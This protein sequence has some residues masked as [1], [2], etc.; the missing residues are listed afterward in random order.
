MNKNKEI[1]LNNKQSLG[2]FMKNH[3]ALYLML[4]P[5]LIIM[6]VFKFLPYYGIQ[7]AFKDYNIFAGNSPLAAIGASTWVGMKHFNKLF[8]SPEFLKVLKNTLVINGSRILFLFPIPIVFAIALGEIRNYRYM[9]FTQT[10][11]FIPY[12]FSWVIIYGIFHSMLGTYGMLNSIVNGLFGMERLAFFRD[13]DL[14]RSMIIFTDGWKSVGYNTVI[15]LAAILSIDPSLYDSARIDG[16][17]RFRQI[18][19]ITIPGILPTIVLMLI[20]KVGHILD[21]GFEQILIFYNPA[22][23]E[24]ADTIQTYVYRMGIG[25]LNFSMATALG[26]FNSLVAFILI[27]GANRVSKRTLNKSIW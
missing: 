23:Y 15:F 9:R 13:Y 24:V 21:V 16:A 27:V 20:L 3:Y 17:G 25:K 22:V 14:F 10:L 1:L 2:S 7:I 5:G 18:W 4:V 19:S 12:F 26:L 6:F 8:G 11:T